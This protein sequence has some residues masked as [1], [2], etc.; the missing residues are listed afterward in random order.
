MK[1]RY[2]GALRIRKMEDRVI[3]RGPC[4]RVVH[5]HPNIR[6]S[7]FQNLDLL[8]TLPLAAQAIPP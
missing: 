5:N 2:Y 7:G 6:S 8:P 4:D 1:E 3:L